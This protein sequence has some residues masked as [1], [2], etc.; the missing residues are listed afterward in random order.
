MRHAAMLLIALLLALFPAACGGGEEDNRRF[1]ERPTVEAPGVPLR[2]VDEAVQTEAV[3]GSMRTISQQLKLKL[4]TDYSGDFGRLS[5]DF[6]G[7]MDGGKLAK[8]GLTE[9]QLTG[10]FYRPS[11]FNLSFSGRSVTITAL[12]PGQRGY[13]QQEFI[14]G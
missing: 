10:S 2:H 12:S 14:I 13:T 11:D 9:Q 7:A 3:I 6:S 1:V 4:A 5:R 8:L